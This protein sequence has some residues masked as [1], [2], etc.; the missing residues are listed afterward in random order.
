MCAQFT[1]RYLLPASCCTQVIY[2][3]GKRMASHVM[4]IASHGT[5]WHAF[6]QADNFACCC[7]GFQRTWHCMGLC[8]TAQLSE[9]TNREQHVFN[10]HFTCT[11]HHARQLNDLS[12]SQRSAWQAVVS[13]ACLHARWR[14]VHSSGDCMRVEVALHAV[15]RLTFSLQAFLDQARCKHIG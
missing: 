11:L 5:S 7:M 10:L 9:L 15:C 14:W 4:A 12:I 13:S 6:I 1:K 2:S 3:H 8:R